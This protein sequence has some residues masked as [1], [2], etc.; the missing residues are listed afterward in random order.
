MIT[1][2]NNNSQKEFDQLEGKLVMR[3]EMER[4]NNNAKKENNASIVYR[5]SKILNDNPDQEEFQIMRIQ[6]F[7]QTG[8]TGAQHKGDYKEALDDCG[9]LKKGFKFHMEVYGFQQRKF[10]N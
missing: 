10:L 3:S 9:R 7:K 1:K 8:L 6:K 5:L 4:I 2:Y